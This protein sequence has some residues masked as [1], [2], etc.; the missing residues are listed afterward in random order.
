[1]IKYLLD[2]RGQCKEVP[3]CNRIHEE[4]LSECGKRYVIPER[5]RWSARKLRDWLKLEKEISNGYNTKFNVEILEVTPTVIEEAEKFIQNALKYNFK[6]MDAMILG[7]AKAYTKENDDMIVV[8]AD[9]GLKSG[10]R[11]IGFPH[12]SLI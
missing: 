2:S 3:K 7:T 1:M 6:S 12:I 8:T 9:K 4:S 11:A 10:M 5:K